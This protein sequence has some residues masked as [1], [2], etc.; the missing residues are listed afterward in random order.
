MTSNN[1]LGSYNVSDKYKTTTDFGQAGY[2]TAATTTKIF[3]NSSFSV[4]SNAATTDAKPDNSTL[5]GALTKG[6]GLNFAVNTSSIDQHRL[7]YASSPNATLSTRVE[8][9]R[10]AVD[11]VSSQITQTKANI[12]DVIRQA[13]NEVRVAAKMTGND[14]AQLYPSSTSNGAVAGLA[15]QAAAPSMAIPVIGS[16]GAAIATAI[17]TSMDAIGNH[18][19]S[20]KRAI[21]ESQIR[22]V[23]ISKQKDPQTEQQFNATYASMFPNETAPRTRLNWEEFIKQNKNLSQFMAVDPDNPN[24]ELFPEFQTLSEQELKIKEI[25][26]SHTRVE[27]QKY[28]A[29]HTGELTHAIKTGN[30]AAVEKM[31]EPLLRDAPIAKED[32][33]A[34]AVESYVSSVL[35]ALRGFFETRVGQHSVLTASVHTTNDKR[36]TLDTALNNEPDPQKFGLSG[37]TFRPT[38]MNA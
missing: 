34:G 20:E 33:S 21:A 7:S 23:L 8:P 38:S 28:D 4:N 2:V 27:E 15:L 32:V 14:P 35:P 24:P 5:L 12:S 3:N 13:Q 17:S 10:A 37:Q 16:T 25:K 36:N 11:N 18:V 19:S 6:T 29:G 30:V 1:G 31:A 22:S 26:L 9:S